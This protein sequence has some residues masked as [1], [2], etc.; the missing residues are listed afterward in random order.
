ML[1]Q[2]SCHCCMKSVIN[3]SKIVKT[4]FIIK[5]AAV[6][7]VQNRFKTHTQGN[8]SKNIIVSHTLA[9]GKAFSQIN[10]SSLFQLGRSQ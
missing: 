6:V 5:L 3:Q 4:G 2:E 9:T 10:F 7:I 1:F 8:T